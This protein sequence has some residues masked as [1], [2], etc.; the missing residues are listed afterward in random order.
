MI[1]LPILFNMLSLSLFTSLT[2]AVNLIAQLPLADS[3]PF[4]NNIQ[5]ATGS[6]ASFIAA[7]GP[8]ALQGVLNNIGSKGSL[9]P[10]VQVGLVVASPSKANP[11]C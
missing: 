3:L 8:V 2:A 6:L 1:G 7:E 9:A 10:G 4:Y 5:R 11:D